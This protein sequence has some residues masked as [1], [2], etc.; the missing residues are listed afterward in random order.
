MHQ[1]TDLGDREDAIVSL[2][3]AD[4]SSQ[5][6]GG[7]VDRWVVSGIDHFEVPEYQSADIVYLFVLQ[8]LIEADD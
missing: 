1:E 5:H 7:E 6:L 3:F 2:I 8:E 4:F